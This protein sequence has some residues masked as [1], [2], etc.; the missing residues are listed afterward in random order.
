ML[1][2]L[3]HPFFFCHWKTWTILKI[4]LKYIGCIFVVSDV[5]FILQNGD[6]YLSLYVN[7]S[8][9]IREKNIYDHHKQVTN[10][11]EGPLSE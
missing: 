11:S 1:M 6:P 2:S 10:P 5:L 9:E 4:D 3:G 7:R 8:P